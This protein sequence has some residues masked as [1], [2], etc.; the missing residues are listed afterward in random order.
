MIKCICFFVRFYIFFCD[1]TGCTGFLGGI[2]VAGGGYDVCFRLGDRGGAVVNFCDYEV[3][4]L[5]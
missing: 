4:I 2:C 3:K 1:R 5:E